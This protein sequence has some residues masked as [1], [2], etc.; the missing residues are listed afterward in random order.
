MQWSLAEGSGF[1]FPGVLDSG[2][3]GEQ[4]MTP[5]QMTTKLQNHQA[6]SMEDTRY[7]M[8]SFRIRRAAGEHKWHG[9]RRSDGLRGAEAR[10]CITQKRR[11]NSVRG[12]G[13]DEAFSQKWRPSGLT[14]YRC[15]SSLFTYGVPTGQLKPNRQGVDVDVWVETRGNYDNYNGNY[16]H[17]K[18]RVT[19][20]MG[21]I[22]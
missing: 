15:P 22:S 11:A 2:E 16:G 13:G 4:A 9:H 21:A 12:S 5:T 14:P 18:G 7:T 19:T 6:A 1:I 10:K 8:H 17:E 3:K 20:R